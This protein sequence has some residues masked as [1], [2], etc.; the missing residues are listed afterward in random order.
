MRAETGPSPPARASSR[1]S[2]GSWRTPR[3]T[4]RGSPTT[5]LAAGPSQGSALSAP[6]SQRGASKVAAAGSFSSNSAKASVGGHRQGVGERRAVRQE[7]GASPRNGQP[8]EQLAQT[9]NPR[10]QGEAQRGLGDLRE[11]VPARAD[12]EVPRPET[13]RQQGG[14]R[15][16]APGGGCS[17]PHHRDRSSSR[18]ASARRRLA[19]QGGI[20]A[21][22]SAARGRRS[23]RIPCR[24]PRRRARRRVRRRRPSG[25]ADRRRGSRPPPRRPRRAG[26]RGPADPG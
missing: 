14:A 3:A 1:R 21:P 5:V 25:P 22:R 13:G 6:S 18:T 26:S 17:L 10:D 4:R 2:R 23:C 15:G 20:R 11:V 24:A 19:R 16:P 9:Q 7:R 8:A 12:A